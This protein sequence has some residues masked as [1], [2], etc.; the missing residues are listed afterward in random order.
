MQTKNKNKKISD[1]EKENLDL[2]IGWQRTQADFDN[3]KKRIEKEK[4]DWIISGKTEA[5]SEILPILDNITLATNHLSEQQRSDQWIAGIIHISKQIE[6]NL[7]DSGITRISPLTGD[8]FDPYEHEAISSNNSTEIDKGCII[9][10]RITGYK[11]AGKI[12]RPAKVEVSNG[13]GESQETK[14]VV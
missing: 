8:K 9:S 11:I 10:T 3:F 13:S 14:E 7:E 5:L 6:K 4:A 1:I 2:R 12:I